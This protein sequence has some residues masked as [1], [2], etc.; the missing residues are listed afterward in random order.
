[1][2]VRE[3]GRHG[4]TWRRVPIPP[5]ARAVFLEWVVGMKPEDLVYPVGHTQ[6]DAELAAVGRAAGLPFRLSGHILRRSYG[7]FA[8]HAGTPPERIRRVYG[9]H[10]VE[11]TLHYIGI[12]AEAEAQDAERFDRHM[13]AFRTSPE[14][15]AEA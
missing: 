8:Y 12:E 1:M 15:L 13:A 4:G 10:S 11:Q 2:N 14:T 3:K 6:A 5:T 9:H 7:R